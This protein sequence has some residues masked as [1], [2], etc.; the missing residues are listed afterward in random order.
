[1]RTAKVLG[2]RRVGSWVAGLAAIGV[3]C[4]GAV[5]AGAAN[6]G[7]NADTNADTSASTNGASE[8]TAS[9]QPT[10][11]LPFARGQSS[12]SAGIHSD[13]GQSGVKNAIDFNPEHGI[14]RAARRGTVDIQHCDGGDWVTI[15]HSGGWRTG[16]YHLENIKVREGQQVNRGAELGDHGTA[17]PCGGSAT[18]DHVHFTLWR[19]QN[20]STNRMAAGNWDGVSYEELEADVAAVVGEP[21]D[22]K[23][24][25]GWRFAEQ[26]AQYSGTATQIRTGQTVQL[27]GTLSY[28]RR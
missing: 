21:V 10:F 7:T 14:V 28:V 17:L 12:G 5:W 11:G 15:D 16:Y 1:M 26:S 8:A 6:A 20:E 23:V 13:N 2:S 18:G 24:F 22:G 19:L 3:V 27:P 9:A 25:G 4:G